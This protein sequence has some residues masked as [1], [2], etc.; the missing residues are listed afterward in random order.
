M[1][2]PKPQNMYSSEETLNTHV[3]VYDQYSSGM[4]QLNNRTVASA[5]SI[6]FIEI[7][8]KRMCHQISESRRATYNNHYE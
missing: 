1:R 4:S 3:D 6:V 2:G 8:Y 5:M 7:H